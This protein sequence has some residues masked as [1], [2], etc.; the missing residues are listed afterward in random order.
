MTSLG[1]GRGSDKDLRRFMRPR[2]CK[3]KFRLVWLARTEESLSQVRMDPVSPMRI[4]RLEGTSSLLK[5]T[6]GFS[7]LC[8]FGRP[9]ARGERELVPNRHVLGDIAILSRDYPAQCHFGVTANYGAFKESCFRELRKMF[10]F[11]KMQNKYLINDLRVS[12]DKNFINLLLML[13]SS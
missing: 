4:S 2:C 8:Q 10:A 11:I 6:L 5:T 3:Q 13:I 1:R 9:R 12:S 7:T